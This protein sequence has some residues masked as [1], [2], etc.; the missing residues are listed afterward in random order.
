[1][2]QNILVPVDLETP[3][4]SDSSL[5]LALR[6]A[7]AVGDQPQ[8]TRIH[9]LSVLPGYNNSMVASYFK[10]SQHQATVHNA[11]DR[12]D[13]FASRNI[14]EGVLHEQHILEGQA[15]PE[16]LEFIRRYKIDLTILRA[17]RHSRLDVLV[18]GST[19]ER[20]V[21][22]SPTSVWVMRK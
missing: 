22:N 2:F 9:L 7:A 13:E 4:F 10:A 18:M 5:Q 19:A 21:K 15:A 6:E 16:I 1:M 11:E 12:L 8:T 17:H 20:V 3:E 14:P